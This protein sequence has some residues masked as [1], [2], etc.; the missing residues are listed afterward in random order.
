[1]EQQGNWILRKMNREQRFLNL[2][3]R[4]TLQLGSHSLCATCFRNVLGINPK[5]WFKIRKLSKQGAVN[6]VCGVRGGMS[7]TSSQRIHCME[8]LDAYIKEQG[9]HMP[10]VDEV[11]LPP[12]KWFTIY[13]YCIAELKADTASEKYFGFRYFEKIVAEYYPKVKVPPEQRFNKCKLCT[14]LKYELQNAGA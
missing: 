6:Y 8:W 2:R 5:R 3:E 1:M 12:G 10:H 13:S 4:L 9:Q 14:D 11:H 7:R